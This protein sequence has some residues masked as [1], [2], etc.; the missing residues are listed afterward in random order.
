M[1]I[2]NRQ[3]EANNNPRPQ[4]TL[5][6]Y[7]S[8]TP[9]NILIQA[10]WYKGFLCYSSVQQMPIQQPR[11]QF[12]NMAGKIKIQKK[13]IL[14]KD[15]L[16]FTLKVW[17]YMQTSSL[18]HKLQN[19]DEQKYPTSSPGNR[20][21][22]FSVGNP[23]PH[24]S[25]TGLSAPYSTTTSSS[26]QFTRRQNSLSTVAHDTVCINSSS[27]VSSQCNSAQNHVSP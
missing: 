15:T 7:H 16:Y 9:S 4:R 14:S 8:R 24:S 23:L 25:L 21:W 3:M 18:R 22:V 17:Q 11:Q 10:S 6:K 26:T 20:C 27:S 19:S 1:K 2:N 13:S 5:L 12:Q